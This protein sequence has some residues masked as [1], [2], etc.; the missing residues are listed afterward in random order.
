MSYD[1]FNNDFTKIINLDELSTSSEEENITRKKILD[2]YLL[3]FKR[4]DSESL[5]PWGDLTYLIESF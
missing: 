2:R 3:D 5:Y 1:N 4:F